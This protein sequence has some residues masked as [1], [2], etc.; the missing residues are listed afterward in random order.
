M[1]STLF[2]LNTADFVKGLLM[3][4]LSTVI[5]IVYQTIE[6]G[7][8]VFDWNAIGTMALTSALAYIMKNLFTN[9]QGQLFKKEK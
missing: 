9:S 3:A 5:T 6:A 7:S 2:T 8:L 4:V 1:Q